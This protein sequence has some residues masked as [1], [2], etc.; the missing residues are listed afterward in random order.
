MEFNKKILILINDSFPF[1]SG[2]TFIESEVKFYNDFNE[3]YIYPFPVKNGIKQMVEVDENINIVKNNNNFGFLNKIFYS[4]KCLLDRVFIQEIRY[5]YKNKKLNVN[6]VIELLSFMCNG[7][8]Y[9][10]NLYNEL[11]NKLDNNSDIYIY[12]YWMYIPAYIAIELKEKLKIK[13]INSIKV[14]SRCHRFDVYEYTHKFSYIPLRKYIVR[15]LDKI[16]SISDDAKK[17]LINRYN[18]LDNKIE[19]SRLGT[20]NDYIKKDV[21]KGKCLRIVSCSWIRPVKQVTKILEAISELEFN[22]EWTHIGDGE[23]FD[24]LKEMSKKLNSN[25]KCI[26]TGALSNSEVKK[27]YINNDYDIFIN[28]SKSE[29]V[30]VSIME[31]MSYGI[32]VIA[33]NVGGTSEIVIN[34]ENGY[35]IQENFEIN[36]LRNY[37]VNI[38]MMNSSEY[39]KMRYNSRMIWEEK[40][41]ANTNYCNF[42]KLLKEI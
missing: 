21:E 30:P 16:F 39:K 18:N 25:I 1:K 7:K 42:I 32:P 12:S 38:Y 9:T 15:N 40:C 22:I 10:N 5:L 6:T 2:E 8:F 17:Y 35:L 23:E 37:I 4:I 20:F 11:I 34:K 33:T 19:I 31:A 28:V 26:F 14:F 36:E 27:T 3:V 29:G 13:K 41:C 24:K